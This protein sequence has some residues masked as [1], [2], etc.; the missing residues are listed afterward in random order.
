MIKEMMITTWQ[1]NKM[2]NLLRVPIM[3]RNPTSIHMIRSR[4]GNKTK[5]KNLISKH[6]KARIQTKYQV[7]LISIMFSN[8][9]YNQM[10]SL[11][12]I[13]QGSGLPTT[14]TTLTN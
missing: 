3:K 5:D 6:I 9:S 12:P 13:S 4:Q 14:K 7:A 8:S 1:V 10:H 2:Y 11:F